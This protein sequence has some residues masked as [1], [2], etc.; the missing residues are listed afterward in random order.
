VNHLFHTFDFVDEPSRSVILAFALTGIMRRSMRAAP[1]FLMDANVADAGKGLIVRILAY[2]LMGD[3]PPLINYGDET[4]EFE[5]RLGAML[6]AGFS[7]ISIDNCT[8]AINGDLLCSVSAEELAYLRVLGFSKMIQV[9]GG[10]LI[11][12]NGNN[13]T[14][15]GDVTHRSHKARLEPTDPNPGERAFDYD[16]MADVIKNRPQLAMDLITIAKAYDAAGRPAKP[17]PWKDFKQYN[18]RVRGALIWLK[19]A[20]P[21][22]TTTQLKAFD[23]K[24]E[25]TLA[26]LEY[27][28]IHFNNEEVTVQKIIAE[29]TQRMPLSPVDAVKNPPPPAAWINPD[30][31][32]ALMTVAGEGPRIDGKKLSDWIKAHLGQRWLID[33]DKKLTVVPRQVMREDGEPKV[34][35]GVAVWKLEAYAP[36]GTIIRDIPL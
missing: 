20:D 8:T 16:P 14:V 34:S 33:Q 36:D 18:E 29:A 23:P 22:L 2:L 11:I 6:M 25:E 12:V 27:W 4:K 30:F 3:A 13:L 28:W 5:K 17:S 32:R 21:Y 10:S 1:L 31:R 19:L 15:V 7:F 26:V 35:N 9:R 24:R